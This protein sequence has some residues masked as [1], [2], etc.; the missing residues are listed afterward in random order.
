MSFLRT[1]TLVIL[2]IL[3]LCGSLFSSALSE[4]AAAMKP[5]SFR[6]LNTGDALTCFRF[7]ALAEPIWAFSN[8][9]SWDSHTNQLLMVGAPHGVSM[10]FIRYQESDNAWRTDSMPAG[11]W[12]G[13]HTYD[14]LTIDSA[15]IFYHLYWADGVAYRYDTRRAVWISPLPA[16]NKGFG[17]LDYFPELNGLVRVVSGSVT[18]FRFNTGT[19]QTLS[20]GLVMG[21]MQSIAQ[22]S[23]AG[24]F[25]LFGGGNG[26][27]N[28]YRLDTNLAVTALKNA[29]FEFDVNQTHLT[30]D[31]VSGKLIMVCADSLFAYDEANDVWQGIAKNPITNYSS[32]HEGVFSIPTYGVIAITSIS[33][34]PVLLYKYANPVAVEKNKVNEQPA[35]SGLS[36]SPNPCHS[37]VTIRLNGVGRSD[38]LINIFDCSG[39]K[40]R[41]FQV[42]PGGLTTAIWDRRNES[43]QLMPRGVYM[44]AMRAEEQTYS[45]A[46]FV[47]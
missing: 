8:G 25:L 42:N 47:E 15:G 44:A 36:V 10:H 41:A 30:A 22:Y 28:L 26:N 17:C 38:G 39:K 27:R 45:K 20:S 32:G 35:I 2:L 7:G 43:G 4:A 14:H 40:I 3:V 16:T 19:W 37:S 1:R 12:S 29:P 33:S 13:A 18:L 6:P 46:I 23:P 31:P 34:W 11:D 24:K 5:G 21:G 9:G